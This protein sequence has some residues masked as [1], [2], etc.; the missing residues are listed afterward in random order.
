MGK[1][2]STEPQEVES[3]MTPM[4]DVTFQLIIF[5]ICTIKFKT[6][7][8]KL[9]TQLPKDV[10]PNPTPLKEQLEKIDIYLHRDATQPDGFYATVA[11][12]RMASAEALRARLIQIKASRGEETKVT[13]HPQKAVTYAHVVKV[14]DECIRAKVYDI[15]FGG[16]PFDA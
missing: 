13:L 11:G 5:F 8:G 7:E 14:V 1:K 2:K 9:A 4:I 3:D 6:L 16:V 10:G 15:T 12:Q